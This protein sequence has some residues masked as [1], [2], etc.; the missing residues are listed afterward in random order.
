MLFGPGSWNWDI[1]AQKTLTVGERRRV[2]LCFDG[3]NVF[4]HFNPGSPNATI[5]DTRDGG[6]SQSQRR[7]DSE[8]ER[9]PNSPTPI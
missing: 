4:N 8:R 7:E 1:G 5:A 3:L 2:Q 9:Q 6:T